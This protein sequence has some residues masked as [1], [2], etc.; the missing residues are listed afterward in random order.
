MSDGE[1]ALVGSVGQNWIDE[2]NRKG[3]WVN[4]IG[5][6]GLRVQV[7]GVRGYRRE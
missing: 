4:N 7:R 6:N 3:N 5:S 1:G 2:P